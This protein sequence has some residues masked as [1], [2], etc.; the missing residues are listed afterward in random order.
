[1]RL[2]SITIG[3]M[4]RE[5][6]GLVLLRLSSSLCLLCV[7]SALCGYLIPFLTIPGGRAAAVRYV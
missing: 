3:G 4:C 6:D 2:L 5:H 7:P 1:M